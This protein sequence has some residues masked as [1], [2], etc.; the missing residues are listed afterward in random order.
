MT[1]P[2]PPAADK[3]S[4]LRN[5]L[6]RVVTALSLLAVLVPLVLWENPYG[7]WGFILV[8]TGLALREF[9]AM[10]PGGSDRIDRAVA[11]ALGLGLSAGLY[12]R[13]QHA[14][15]LVA[16]VVVLVMTYG[17][18]RF[19][20]METIGP[21]VSLWITGILYCGILCTC[22]S[23]LKRFDGTGYWVILAMTVSWF[24]DTGAYFTGKAL[25]GPKIYPAISPNKTWSGSLGGLAASVGAGVLAKLWYLPGLGWGDVFLV[26][27]PAGL[28]GQVGDFA[29]SMFKRSFGVKD[30][31]TL[32]PG[33]GGML[34]RVDALMF[35]S[36]YFYFYVTFCFGK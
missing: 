4:W 20:V 24:G 2:A 8:A 14:L 23:L 19:R 30:S 29:E 6:L 22:L 1:D 11:L 35:V 36:A 5:T 25:G 27:V 31:G 34:D 18:L 7:L 10:A 33:H 15:P 28:L 3:S 16:G 32:L 17:V 12:F 21:R 26:C 9:F 13:P